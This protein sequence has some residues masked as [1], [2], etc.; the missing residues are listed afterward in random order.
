MEFELLALLGD[1]AGQVLSRDEILNALRGV[2]FDGQDRSVDVCIG[3]LRRKLKDDPRRPRRI[4]TVW[5]KG[6]L[7][8]PRDWEG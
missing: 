4:K 5:G 6:Y 1:R 3:K 2:D 7:L 8:S